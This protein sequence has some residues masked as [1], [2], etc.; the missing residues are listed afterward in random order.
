MAPAMSIA[1]FAVDIALSLPES[2]EL[3]GD[4]LR[5]A[6]LSLKRAD[7]AGEPADVG[8]HLLGDGCVIEGRIA[9]DLVGDETRLLGGK[10]ALGGLHGQRRVGAER[11]LRVH[12]GADGRSGDARMLPD[13]PLR[14]R[15]R[16]KSPVAGRGR[17][18]ASAYVEQ[19]LGDA[20]LHAEVRPQT[21]APV[22]VGDALL[23]RVDA[24]PRPVGAGAART[25]N[26]PDVISREIDAR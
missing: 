13:E 16:G 18:V 2:S 22:A 8:D 4:Q 17:P 19:D 3:R 21:I 23:D 1:S 7:L 25:R 11:A 10:Q 9:R 6:D 15:E 12:D 20:A 26:D 14:G 5:V 24:V